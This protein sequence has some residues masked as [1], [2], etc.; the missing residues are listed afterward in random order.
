MG[1]TASNSSFLRG[2]G[3]TMSPSIDH[4]EN[5]TNNTTGWSTH[6]KEE[7]RS[8]TPGLGLRLPSVGVS[9]YPNLMMGQS[10]LFPNKPTTLDL[11]GLGIGPAGGGPS[12]EFSD[13]LTSM[14]GG[15]DVS[16]ASF[17][18][19]SAG[20]NWEDAGDRKPELL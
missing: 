17:G 15:L 18:V 1:A 11:L 16:G 3:F 5:T 9:N 2:L 8:G 4:Q 6:A 10:S 14:S 12:D 20:E 13:F 7:N 19:N